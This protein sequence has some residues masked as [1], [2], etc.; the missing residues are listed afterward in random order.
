M[1]TGV[2]LKPHLSVPGLKL[3]REAAKLFSLIRCLVYDSDAVSA[4]PSAASAA[5]VAKST[6]VCE[7]ID[8]L[9]IEEDVF[10][11]Q[12]INFLQGAVNAL[13]YGHVMLNLPQ[14]EKALSLF[15]DMEV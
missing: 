9:G 15:D 11:F 12:N 6:T 1:D 7:I 13:E 5:N 3:I 2:T 4:Y 14:P 8:I 10:R